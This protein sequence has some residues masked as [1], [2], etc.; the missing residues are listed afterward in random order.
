[1]PKEEGENID[2][3]PV[4]GEREMDQE[5]GKVH[6][7][8]ISFNQQGWKREHTRRLAKRISFLR[9]QAIQLDK[10]NRNGEG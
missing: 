8:P 5:G 1:M 10:T 4:E 9:N 2:L 3:W 7:S 6:F